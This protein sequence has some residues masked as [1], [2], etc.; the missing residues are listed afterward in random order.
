MTRIRE[1]VRYSLPLEF[2]SSNSAAVVLSSAV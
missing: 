2:D 1:T